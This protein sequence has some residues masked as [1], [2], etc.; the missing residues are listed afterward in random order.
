MRR[1]EIFGT[2]NLNDV[3]ENIS[4]L[5]LF[6]HILVALVYFI[7][8]VFSFPNFFQSIVDIS[9]RVGPLLPKRMDM[10]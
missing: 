4:S 5:H 9:F 7:S 6:L 8:I 1:G 10:E 3:N 2:V